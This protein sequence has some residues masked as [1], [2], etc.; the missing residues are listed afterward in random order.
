[1][2]L[3]AHAHAPFHSLAFGRQAPSTVDPRGASNENLPRIRLTIPKR[4]RRHPPQRSQR[5]QRLSHEKRWESEEGGCEEGLGLGFSRALFGG[6]I[7]QVGG[8]RRPIQGLSG[9]LV[10]EPRPKGG[11]FGG[12]ALLRKCLGRRRRSCDGE[13]RSLTFSAH[14]TQSSPTTST[15]F[16]SQP[17]RQRTHR[18]AAH[19]GGM[20]SSTASSNRFRQGP[21]VSSPPQR[22]GLG[23]K[24]GAKGGRVRCARFF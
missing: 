8:H 6:A 19:T 2:M 17:Q 10:V 20:A 1:M 4:S 11:A 15:P 3:D 14:E 16:P 23:G 18:G 22:R 7:S 13:H 9:R 12:L 21:G 5:P 24:G